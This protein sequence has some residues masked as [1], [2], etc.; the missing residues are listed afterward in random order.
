MDTSK[1]QEAARAE[2]D[3]LELVAADER[4][5]LQALIWTVVLDQPLCRVAPGRR[6]LFSEPR[7]REG[8]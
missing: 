6:P 8:T 4:Q 5:R 2:V 3:R 7:K 1:K